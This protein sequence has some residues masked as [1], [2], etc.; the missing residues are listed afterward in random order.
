MLHIG[1]GIPQS[2]S[3]MEHMGKVTDLVLLLDDIPEILLW[4]SAP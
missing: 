2:C 4:L 3:F 1:P